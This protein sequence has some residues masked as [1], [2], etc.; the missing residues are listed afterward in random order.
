MSHPRVR[1]VLAVLAVALLA[2]APVVGATLTPPP[3]VESVSEAPRR[4]RLDLSEHVEEYDA[5]M[6][7]H[8]PVPTTAQGIGPGS[9]LFIRMDGGLYGCTAN[10]LWTAGGKTYLGAAGH[11]FLPEGKSAT[12]GPG[13]DYD[14]A[15][16]TVSVCVSACNFGGQAGFVFTG[17]TAPLGAV[18]Y[19]RQTQDNADL[20]NDF[21][22]VEVPSTLHHLLRPSMPVFQGPTTTGN[23]TTRGLMCHFG[24]GVGV[25]EVYPTHARMGLGW[26][27]V[28]SA[29]SWHAALAAAPGD[30][31]SAVQSCVADAAGV[32]GVAA[33]GVLTHI[34][35]GFI[36][37]TTVGKAVHM[38][39]QANLELQIVLGTH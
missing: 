39:R 38:G 4:L 1:P 9:H 6:A 11:C 27:E 29:G 24:N 16:S 2:A 5:A 23:V 15:G 3:S 22:V 18:A 17:T 28:T 34:A 7:T 30:S 31:G 33:I 25:G 14:P 32:H 35:G 20:G 10:F 26:I 21:G 13:A 12:H 8:V 19:A 37:G 36:V